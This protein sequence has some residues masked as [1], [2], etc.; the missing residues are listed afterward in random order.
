MY[1]K[2]SREIDLI[3]EKFNT[4][5]IKL[6]FNFYEHLSIVELYQTGDDAILYEAYRLL[7]PNTSSEEYYKDEFASPV[8]ILLNKIFQIKLIDFRNTIKTMKLLKS[9]EYSSYLT[10]LKVSVRNMGHTKFGG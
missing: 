9:K 2:T 8:R 6:P 10:E 5:P 3:C 4:C 1:K 7:Y